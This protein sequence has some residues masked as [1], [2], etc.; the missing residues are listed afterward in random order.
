MNRDIIEVPHSLKV[1]DILNSL[2]SSLDGLSWGEARKRIQIYGK[3]TLEEEKINRWKIF[4]RQ[5]NSPLIYILLIAALISLLVGEIKDFFVITSL[6][7]ANGVIGYFQEIKA[8]VSIRSLKKLTESKVKVIR[9]GK[10]V[11]IPS[12]ELVPG[13]IVVLSEGDLVTAD[14]RL[15]D[16]K[17]LLIDESSITGESIPVEKDHS[18]ILPKETLPYELKNMALS[19]TTVVRGSGIGVVVRTGKMTYFA[20]ITEKVKEKPPLSPVIKALK[21]FTRRYVIFVIF[22][23]TIVGIIAYYQG[24]R[25][26]EIAMIL[27]SQLVSSV[28]EGLPIVITLTL[29]VGALALSKR[30]TLVRY[31]PAVEVLGS[32]TTIVIDKTGTIT[33]G[34]LAVKEVFAKDEEML[35]VVSALCNN[36]RDGHGDPIDRALAKWLGEEYEKI[37]SLY[38]RVKEYPFDVKHRFMATINEFK[39]KKTLFIKGAYESLKEIAINRDLKEFDRILEKMTENGLRVLAFGYG[40][41]NGDDFS[42]WKIRIVGLIGFYDPPKEGVREAVEV[43]RRAGIRIIMITGDHLLTAKAIAKEVGIWRERDLILTGKD[44]DSLDDKE[45]YKV[46]EKTTV[47]ARALPEHKYRVVRVLQENDEIVA[48][49]GDGVNDV[50]ALRV[51]DLGIAMGS[52][53]EAAKSVAK[54]V[55][56]DNDLRIIIDAIKQGRVIA[57][58]LRKV[59]YYL[60]STSIGEVILI[61]LSILLGLPLP[62]FAIQIL[63]INLVTDGVQDKTFPLCKE[64][65]DVMDRLPRRPE[66]LFF[67]GYQMARILY[68]GL[69]MGLTNLF[70]YMH[71]LNIYEYAIVNSIIFTSSVVVQW[72]NGIQAQ[73]EKEPFFKNVKK[74]LTINPYIFL[75]ILASMVLQLIALYLVPDWFKTVPLPIEG[76][77]YVL[78][79]SLICFFAVEIWKWIEY[80]INKVRK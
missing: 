74:S 64:E 25:I 23:L 17:G 38:P 29:V 62:L 36:F 4:L 20:R 68:F 56:V 51:A 80:L 53:T 13:D 71:L 44:I 39:G 78:L 21:V 6:V 31:L 37:R 46:L 73:K 7:F 52:G 22:F 67:D 1:E 72:F 43:A 32:A 8:E 5:F 30:K 16:S 54:M 77:L 35:K 45:L 24:R 33:E 18:A 11:E 9:E 34:K 69:L 26:L 55:I 41:W 42:K 61:S 19:G 79:V 66:K 2:G 28:P 60:I 58:N 70:L 65:T 50:P 49:T 10:I 63:W 48:V 59:V 12:S 14:I 15:I 47:I 3:N 57:D 75:G 27:I 40:E 76:W